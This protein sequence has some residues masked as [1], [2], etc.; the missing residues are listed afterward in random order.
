LKGIRDRVFAAVPRGFFR[1]VRILLA[2]SASLLLAA[3]GL[4][5]G[6]AKVGTFGF[7]YDGM[8]TGARQTALGQADVAGAFGATATQLNVAPLPEGDGVTAS[9]DRNFFLADI[10]FEIWG[11]VVEARGLRL[12]YS[13]FRSFMDPQLVRTAYNPEGT[14][15]TF[16]AGDDIDVVSLGYDLGRLLDEE[17][18]WAWT[19]GAAWRRYHSFLAESEIDEDTWDLGTTVAWTTPHPHGWARLAAAV[20]RQN[21]ANREAV[22]DERAFSLPA[23]WRMGATLEATFG[24]A[25]GGAEAFRFLMAITRRTY[26]GEWI[27]GGSEH[28]GVEL[29][30]AGL[31]VLR[32]GAS[33]RLPG[34][35]NSWGLGLILDRDFMRSFAVSADFGRYETAIEWVDMWSV[36]ARYSF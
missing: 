30:G 1:M 5:A 3:P 26:A 21:L 31:L 36:R 24:E 14:G 35:F 19:V 25:G 33:T 13:R 12:G 29:T 27:D 20:S 34:T 32:T 2:L 10:D 23:S 22:W 16:D 7:I 15:E 6:F 11:A 8:F 17:G 28:F 4:A 18:R 9:Y